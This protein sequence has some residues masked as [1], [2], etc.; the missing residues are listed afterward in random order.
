M[1]TKIN[2]KMTLSVFA[3]AMLAWASSCKN[4]SSGGGSGGI[5]N[6]KLCR[7]SKGT[8][9]G[10][11]CDCPSG[12]DNSSSN[13]NV[14]VRNN[15]RDNDSYIAAKQRCADD[16]FYWD[17]R[18]DRC[19]T[20]RNAYDA[21]L[22]SYTAME[23]ENKQY[24]WNNDVSSSLNKCQREEP[25]NQLLCLKSLHYWNYSTGRCQL[26]SGQEKKN[27]CQTYGAQVGATWLEERVECRC[28]Q[29][30]QIFDGRS[31]VP[32]NMLVNGFH[33]PNYGCT[34]TGG[35]WYGGGQQNYNC[36]CGYYGNNQGYQTQ[37]NPYYN[38]CRSPNYQYNCPYWDGGTCRQAPGGAVLIYDLVL[39]WA[40]K[41]ILD[42]LFD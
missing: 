2:L 3:F 12:Y 18:Y 30:G 1:F 37:W 36:E 33:N 10:N 27:L 25:T 40:T 42:S 6:D 41:S 7:D 15:D 31:C 39:G 38:M 28:Q 23:C 4:S 5:G 29:S 24:F 17:P 22:R 16:G 26:R 19:D 13:V 8:W 11:Y 35:N 20:N 34:N 21:D 9:T 14:C 32:D